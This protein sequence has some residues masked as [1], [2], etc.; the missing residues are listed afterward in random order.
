VSC[1][2]PAYSGR[3]FFNGASARIPFRRPLG[4]DLRAVIG[5]TALR[6]GCAGAAGQ[7]LVVEQVD[8]R[9]Q[10][11]A[12]R[13]IGLEQVVQV[14]AGK[15]ARGGTAALRIERARIVDVAR[16]LDIDRAEAGESEPA[17]G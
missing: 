3:R 8:D 15:F 13:F 6:D 14:S 2:G 9:E 16:V 10:R 4:F 11:A 17:A 12:E 5:Q 1:A 7:V